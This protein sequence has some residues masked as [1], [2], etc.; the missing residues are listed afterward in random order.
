[1]PKNIPAANASTKKAATNIYPARAGARGGQKNGKRCEP[2]MDDTQK[3]MPHRKH[4][5]CKVTAMTYYNL[6][7]L[8]KMEKCGDDVGRVV[9][10]LTRDRMIM[11]GENKWEK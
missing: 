5:S 2:C 10:K 6:R 8:A 4:L 11:L 9:D 3:K 1:M 7:K